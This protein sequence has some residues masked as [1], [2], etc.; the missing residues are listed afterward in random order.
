[1][2][3]AILW[4]IGEYANKIIN[5]YDIPDDLFEMVVDSNYRKKETNWLDYKIQSPDRIIDADSELIVI[6]S[7]LYRAE[8]EGK[9]R[10]LFSSKR[11]MFIDDYL[12]KF[13]WKKDLKK[14]AINH[15]WQWFGGISYAQCGDDLFVMNLFNNLGMKTFSYLDIGAHNPYI[16]SNTALFYQRGCR[17][18]N[19]EA[20]PNLI[21]D[22]NKYRPDDINLNVGIGVKE[23]YMPFYMID[24]SSGLNSF[25]KETIEERI[26]NWENKD[27]K[28]DIINV[29]VITLNTLIKRY[30]KNI[31]PDFLT[32]DIEGMDY[33]VLSNFDLNVN[34]PIVIDVEIIGDIGCR[35][36]KMLDNQGYKA[37][38]RCGSNLIFIKSELFA[39]AVLKEKVI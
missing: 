23:E 39:Q 30:C 6:G 26:S 10:E 33:D 35:M 5:Q 38:F 15:S 7:E 13:C 25:S 20:N 29:P 9:I 36:K 4:G 24:A 19:V 34:G 21:G 12:N 28:L 37:I 18:V 27:I 31:F 8:I 11:S 17:G 2:K 16:I 1:M 32:I 22:F 3:K 14:Q